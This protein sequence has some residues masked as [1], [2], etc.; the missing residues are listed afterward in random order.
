MKKNY[1]FLFLTLLLTATVSL[2]AIAQTVFKGK[3]V[4]GEN[5]E[6]LI[7]AAVSIISGGTGGAITNYEGEFAIK[8][9][10]FPA[11]VKI[12][13]TGYQ[14]QEIDIADANQRLVVKLSSGDVVLEETVIRGQRIDDKQKAAR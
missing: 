12:F 5:G 6:D 1:I 9:D 10:K 2:S 4:D 8:I 7:G 3:V 14:A 13:Y 11:K